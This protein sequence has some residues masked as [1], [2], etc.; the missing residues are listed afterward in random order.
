MLIRY[1]CSRCKDTFDLEKQDEWSYYCFHCGKGIL[2]TYKLIK[3][4]QK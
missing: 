1:K 4:V 3:R 2:R